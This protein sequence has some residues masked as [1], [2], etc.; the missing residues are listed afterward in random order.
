[1]YYVKRKR[2]SLAAIFFDI[3]KLIPLSGETPPRLV[4]ASDSL[5]CERCI[6][7]RTVTE[8]SLM[9]LKPLFLDI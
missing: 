6:S 2:L 8:K 4:G 9:T 7:L 5:R 1:M 3:S